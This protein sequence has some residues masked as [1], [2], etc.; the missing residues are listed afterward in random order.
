M[1][2]NSSSG[3]SPVPERRRGRAVGLGSAWP[4]WGLALTLIC[5]PGS[6]DISLNCLPL[7]FALAVLSVP[8]DLAAARLGTR[9]LEE[10][11]R[12]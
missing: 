10:T 6:I 2:W 9:R 1:W 7:L 11:G 3:P 5:V 4:R 8:S 12:P